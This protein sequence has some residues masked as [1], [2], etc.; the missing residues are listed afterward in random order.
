MQCK[1]VKIKLAAFH[2][3]HYNEIKGTAG[4]EKTGRGKRMN[5]K[6]LEYVVEI[7]RCGSIN[8][9]SQNLFLSQ[10][11]LSSSLKHLEE[12]LHFQIFKRQKSGVELTPEGALLVE[13]AQEILRQTDKI[14]R[15]PTLFEQNNNLSV[16]CTYSSIFMQS[17]MA[18][19]RNAKTDVHDIFKETGLIQ[20]LQDVMQNKYRM[21]IFYC[22]SNRKGRHERFADE[23]NLAL[24][25]LASSVP[26]NVIAAEH[27]ILAR[28]G[29]VLF[30]EI[31]RSHFVTYENFDFSD[32]LQVLGFQ[33]ERKVLYVF[34]RGGLLDTVGQSDY[35]AVTMKCLP[36]ELN[37]TGCV[38][39]P[40]QGLEVGVDIFLLR[41]RSYGM[42]FREKQFV[43][44]LRR[45]LAAL[46]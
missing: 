18:F 36:R 17:F 24:E 11:N 2:C 7:A 12:E 33:D 16:S 10:P 26:V 41:H 13:S 9:A 31:A 35:I 46:R 30:P 6:G 40:I 34:D 44:A 20:T 8:K 28:K 5:L 38:A 21:S 1:A 27:N 39:L 25:P 32:W 3:R 23:Y 37:R 42:N 19:R 29:Y 22:F 45:D 14:R 43:Q 15:I 4:F